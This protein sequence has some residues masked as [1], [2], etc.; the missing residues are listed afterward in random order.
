LLTSG[1]KLFVQPAV[2]TAVGALLGLRG[3]GL[4]AVAVVSALPTAQN[5]FTYATRYGRAQILAR[6]TI[7]VTTILCVPVMLAI[8]VVLG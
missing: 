5:V 1:L 3:H 6:D 7:L 2:A 4:L 8:A